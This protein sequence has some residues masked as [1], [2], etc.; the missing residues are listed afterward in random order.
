LDIGGRVRF[1]LRGPDRISSGR[2]GS[3]S[4]VTLLTG[5]SASHHTGFDRLVFTFDGPLPAQW[6]ISEVPGIVAD[7]SGLA[8]PVYG[9]AFLEITCSPAAAHDDDGGITVPLRMAPGLPNL[10]EI[11]RAGDFE[12]IVTIGVGLVQAAVREAFT[13]TSP[14]RLVVDIEAS[15]S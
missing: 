8:V 2:P 15:F 9:A 3:M 4:P 13:L 11:V 10:V 1:T 7:G 12:G 6:T 5:I 14:N